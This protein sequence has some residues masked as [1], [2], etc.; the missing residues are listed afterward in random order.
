MKR[1]TFALDDG[2]LRLLKKRV[3]EEGRSVQALAGDLLRRGLARPKM[4]ECRLELQGWHADELPGVDLVDRDKLFDLMDDN[5]ATRP[6]I[7]R[8]H[9]P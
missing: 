9:R 6:N 1:T 5:L 3:A 2:L 8:G 4:S 7:S